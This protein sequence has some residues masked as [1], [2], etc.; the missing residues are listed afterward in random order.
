MQ[1]GFLV[2]TAAQVDAGL[3]LQARTLVPCFIHV[4]PCGIRGLLPDI[5]GIAPHHAVGRLAP[6]VV[7]DVGGA[8]FERAA[9]LVDLHNHLD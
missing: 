9:A 7:Q 3:A 5:D 2:V 1:N 8:R 6:D 4:A